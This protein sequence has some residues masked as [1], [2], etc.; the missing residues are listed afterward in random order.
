MSSTSDAATAPIAITSAAALHES[1]GWLVRTLL[2]RA[3]LRLGNPRAEEDAK[4]YQGRLAD[5]LQIHTALQLMTSLSKSQPKDSRRLAEVRALLKESLLEALQDEAAGL[6]KS[7]T[8]FLPPMMKPRKVRLEISRVDILQVSDINQKGQSFDMELFV[9]GTFIDGARDEALHSASD[10]FP[11][12]GIVAGA[13]LAL[14]RKMRSSHPSLT[15]HAA[16][17]AAADCRRFASAMVQSSAGPPSAR[18]R[19]GF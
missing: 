10:V 12:D 17:D 18:R 2:H 11:L 19:S 1:D 7:A 8:T 16:P 6:T 13:T 3:F 5:D 4:V 14:P 15:W 9:Q